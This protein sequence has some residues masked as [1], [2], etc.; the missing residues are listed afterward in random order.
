[1]TKS[2]KLLIFPSELENI[3]RVERLIDEISS[4]HNLSSEIYGKISVALIE[5]V[6]NAILHGNQLDVTKKVKVKYN[7]DDESISFIVWDEGKGFDFS[8]I[9][10]PTLPENLEKTH[11]RGVFLMNH[12]ADDIEFG[13]NG[14]IVEMK[15]IF[16]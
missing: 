16:G 12:L 5:A 11:G 13:E 14:A 8:N 4:S 2:E 9:P 7:I 1:M 10:D 6:N 15:F 3:S